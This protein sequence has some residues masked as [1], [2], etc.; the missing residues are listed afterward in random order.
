MQAVGGI[1]MTIAADHFDD[2]FR[3]LWERDPFPWQRRLARQVCE[4]KWPSAIDLPTAS[5]KTACLDVAVFALAVQSGTSPAERTIGRRL[6]F[7]VNRRVIVDEAN[8]RARH[9]A[10]KLA[11]SNPTTEPVL[12]RVANALR[13]IAGDAHALP[14]DVATLRGGIYR[15]NRW[16]RSATQP[17][18]ITSTIDQ[19]GS[20]L[21][22]RGY[23][24]TEFARPVHAA[25]IAND[26]TILVDEA[27]I[28]E[29]FVQMLD[30]V[31]MYRSER[32]ATEPV[33][34]PFAV[35]LMSATRSTEPS[36]DV[37]RLGDDDRA[38]PLLAKRLSVR[39]PVVLDM[40]AGGNET[41]QMARL[42]VEKAQQ[43]AAEGSRTVAIIANRVATA[44]SVYER[45]KTLAGENRNSVTPEVL[46]AI[47]RM[48]PIDR[49]NVTRTI[50]ERVGAQQKAS[51]DA[52]P[53]FVAATQC[54]EVGADFDF[55]AIVSECA[56]LDAL[57]QRFGRL[58]RTG[59][60][61]ETRGCVVI[62]AD[63]LSGDDPIYG[64]ALAETWRWLNSIAE[65][66]KPPVVDFGI[67][68]MEK[69]LENQ[70]I[71][72]LL[73]PRV[74]GPV[75]L[76]AYVD[77]WVQT[78]P[79][80]RPDPDVALFIH[81]PKRGE[82]DV[83]ICWRAD[84]PE[85]HKDT[86]VEIISLC[87][88]ISPECMPVP[89]GLV[90]KWLSGGATADGER[91][92]TLEALTPADDDSTNEGSR[93]R[94]SAQY[95]G[96]GEVTAPSISR[97]ALAWRGPSKSDL[98]GK[99]GEV[100]PGDTLVLPASSG[101]WS[102]FGHIPNAPP[103]PLEHT[104]ESPVEQA[105]LAQL[106]VAERAYRQ[107]RRQ[108]I[109][110]LTHHRLKQWP[111][112]EA[113]ESLANWLSDPE[114]NLHLSDLRALLVEISEMMPHGETI[115][116]EA[117]RYLGRPQNGLTV[118]RYHGATGAVLASRRLMPQ[119]E[120]EFSDFAIPSLDDGGDEMS[121]TT[122]REPISLRGHTQHVREELECAIACL[123]VGIWS[124]VLRS[125]AER[126]DWGKA[127]DRFQALLINGDLDDASAQPKL[128]AKSERIPT[129]PVK[130]QRA[131]NRSGLPEG[132]RHEMLSL[133]LAERD[134]N[135]LTCDER[136]LILHLIAAHHGRARAFAPV[137]A[138]PAP[139]VVGLGALAGNLMLTAQERS[140]TPSYRLDSGIGERFW[141]L[142]RRF[143]WWGLAYLE[144][145]LRLADQAASARENEP[146]NEV[147]QDQAAEIET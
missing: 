63:Q 39:K 60:D 35:V 103:D 43:F 97:V 134:L 76:P 11:N 25:V 83:N 114:V 138:D 79:A 120:C 87:P 88:P 142:T 107:Y 45:L 95:G 90:R 141:K 122:R 31:R 70:N 54:L 67:S 27:H 86:W 117:V 110:R 109:L 10:R 100:R 91:G 12:W 133:Q 111:Q 72:P 46:L 28:S 68:V 131:R 15:D 85:S 7:V 61:I 53:M 13:E 16:V 38:H 93:N 80:P 129:D 74:N 147:Q 94:R 75:M 119:D 132:F 24:V 146:Q 145:V 21:L 140:A 135:S 130:R 106:D 99:P 127:D 77:A 36:V 49:D 56:S 5:G 48:R 52:S 47:G 62:R 58:N 65:P 41:D 96:G 26:S 66:N 116:A 37:L 64:A 69:Q 29:P 1:T 50:Q 124:E 22:F 81:G 23:G 108:V 19:V 118:E 112:G 84:L 89:I 101:G 17:T 8:Q 144:T 136:D 73:A 123:P 30:A 115:I 105:Q 32:W 71:T 9:I 143:G 2:Y 18:I 6:F 44:K 121:R 20:R 3:E 4:G 42:L 59:R 92:D 126:H 139:P 113:T 98:I 55:D 78:S 14:L 40:T 33:R 104:H 57:R 137:I 34:T 125:A 128:W 102:I 82:P 51:P